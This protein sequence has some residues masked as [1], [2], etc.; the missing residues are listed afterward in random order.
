MGSGVIRLLRTPLREGEPP[1]AMC[2]VDQGLH[3]AGNKKGEKMPRTTR[4]PTIL[5]D[6]RIQWELPDNEANRTMVQGLLP[7][8]ENPPFAYSVEFPEDHMEE[9]Q[10]HEVP[11]EPV[12]VPHADP[13][14]APPILKKRGRKPSRSKETSVPGD[15]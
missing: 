10:V 9:D 2:N 1:Y 14:P 7:T 15:E 6:K 13:Q 12:H 4:L 3:V 8:R 5:E 11:G